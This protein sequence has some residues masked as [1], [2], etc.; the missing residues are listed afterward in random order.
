MVIVTEI[1]ALAVLLA[2]IWW[3]SGYDSRV[4]GENKAEDLTRRILRCVATLILAGIF[5]G[6]SPLKLGYFFVPLILIVPVSLGL[7]WCGCLSEFLSRRFR[8]LIDPEDKRPFDPRQ[9]ERQLD[10]V[11][12]LIRNGKKAEAIQLCESLKLS[13]EADLA[14]LE[15]TLEH[16]GVPQTA[17]KKASPLSAAGQLRRE[18]KFTEAERILNSLLAKAPQNV[19]AAMMLM[20]L[21]AQDLQNP[22]KAHEVLRALERQVHVPPG[23]I[24][25]ARRSIAEWSR[26][27]PP[28]KEAPASSKSVEELLAA[29]CFGTAIEVLEQKIQEQPQN[30]DL[31]LKLAEAHGRYCGDLKR[32]E[33]ILGQMKNSF[34]FSTEQIQAATRRLGEWRAATK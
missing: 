30:F 27:L 33:K 34:A 32:A 22:A 28:P 19:D 8:W 15:L 6:L 10:T 24:E 25:F 31:W 23:H 7:L 1:T 12:E 2:A 4:L 20:R 21:Y 18:G 16:L 26:P 3:L 9:S 14:A 29:R 5:F 11:G 13:G 17:V